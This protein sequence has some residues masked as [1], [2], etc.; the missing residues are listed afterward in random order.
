MGIA[1]SF[2]NSRLERWYIGIFFTEEFSIVVS[3]FTGKN[4]I[5]I[6]FAVLEYIKSCK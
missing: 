3:L 2:L 6:Y 1:N 4:F 5:Q